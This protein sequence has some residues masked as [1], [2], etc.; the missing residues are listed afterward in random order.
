MCFIKKIVI[1]HLPVAIFFVYCIIMLVRFSSFV[2][3]FKYLFT[4]A[5]VAYEKW[6]TF[7]YG[8]WKGII[9]I[10]VNFKKRVSKFTVFRLEYFT[11]VTIFSR[12]NMG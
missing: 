11:I 4:L 7:I 10:Y 9:E 2:S 5:Y 1:W 8:K 6:A 12:Y 3:M